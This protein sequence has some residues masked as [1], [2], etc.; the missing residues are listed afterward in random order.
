MQKEAEQT[1]AV[2]QRAAEPAE[3]TDKSAAPATATQ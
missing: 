3:S 1:S 2:A